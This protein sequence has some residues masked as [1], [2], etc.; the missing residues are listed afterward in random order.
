M[1]RRPLDELKDLEICGCLGF[2]EVLLE[3][4]AAVSAAPPETAEQAAVPVERL[5]DTDV[6]VSLRP[7]QRPPLPDEGAVD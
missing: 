4:A 6:N 5:P 7:S 3:G 1:K 2:L